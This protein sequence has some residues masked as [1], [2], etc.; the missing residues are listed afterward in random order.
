MPWIEE[1]IILKIIY[2][3]HTGKYG[4]LAAAGL[5][6]NLIHENIS[7]EELVS[8]FNKYD[9]PTL[10]PSFIGNDTQGV[11]VYALGTLKESKLINKI[12]TSF[13]TTFCTDGSPLLMIDALP[14]VKSP[15]NIILPL[16]SLNWF[17]KLGDILLPYLVWQNI[18]VISSQVYNHEL[19]YQYLIMD[20]SGDEK[21]WINCLR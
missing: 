17:N 18:S 19:D 16:L 14:H 1:C 13:K 6:L 15:L 7:Y 3:C 4:A 9:C 20:N 8:F 2:Y 21:G 12:V 5:H 10:T 11:S